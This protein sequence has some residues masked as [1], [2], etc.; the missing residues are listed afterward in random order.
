LCS[1]WIS[2]SRPCISWTDVAII[3]G[4]LDTK[5]VLNLSISQS[6]RDKQRLLLR[7]PRVSQ[8]SFSWVQAVLM[9]LEC[10]RSRHISNT[11]WYTQ[12]HPVAS[13]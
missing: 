12:T 11:S 5:S 3:W 7:V 4:T 10:P 9:D 8:F 6:S 1:L 2:S 13:H